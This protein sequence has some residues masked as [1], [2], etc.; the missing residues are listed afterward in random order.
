[1]PT[2]QKLVAVGQG[3]LWEDFKKGEL[4]RG[5]CKKDYYSNGGGVRGGEQLKF[6]FLLQRSYTRS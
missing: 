6:F 4:Y 5:K 3:V 1:M 2:A